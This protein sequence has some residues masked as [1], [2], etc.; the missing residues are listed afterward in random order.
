[1]SPFAIL[2]VSAVFVSYASAIGIAF[3]PI[4]SR[5]HKLW[6][7]AYAG[8]MLTTALSGFGMYNFGGP[9]MFHIF[10]IVTITGI[11]LGLRS[12]WKFSKNAG[13][14]VSGRPLFPHGLQLH[15]AEYGSRRPDATAL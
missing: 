3:A 8:G 13:Q 5:S 14:E 10:S 9:S 1:M 4:G 12:I 6:G 7:R 2:H 15:G 11:T